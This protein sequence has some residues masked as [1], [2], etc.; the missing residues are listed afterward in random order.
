MLKFIRKVYFH[1]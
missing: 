1:I